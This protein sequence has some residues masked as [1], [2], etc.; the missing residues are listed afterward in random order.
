MRSYSKIML[1]PALQILY[2][3]EEIGGIIS[4]P[5]TIT[6]KGYIRVVHQGFD[7]TLTAWR[8]QRLSEHPET[9]RTLCDLFNQLIFMGNFRAS[10]WF[11]KERAKLL[12]KNIAWTWLEHKTKRPATIEDQSYIL[13]KYIIPQSGSKSVQELT[14]QDFYWIRENHGDTQ[15]ANDIRSVAGAILNWAWKEGMMDRQ[16]FLPV[17]SVPKKPTPYIEHNDRWRIYA[18]IEPGYQDPVLLSIE[19]GMRVGEICALRWDAI[20]LEHGIIKI[21]RSLSKYQVVDMRKGGDEIW[22]Q[23]TDKV[24]TMLE[25]RRKVSKSHWVFIGKKG[26]H[27][28]TNYVSNAF[29]RAA[30][31]CGL[32]HARLH[33]CRH[34]IAID[35]G[36]EGKSLEETQE[37][38]GHRERKTTEGYRGMMGFRRLRAAVE[39]ERR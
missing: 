1:T 10:D 6:Q 12:I 33:H 4:M 29:K 7:K 8:N 35:D 19:M 37:R 23:M 20:N 16:L 14:R 9:T 21:I 27:L 38:L 30:R 36:L 18:K 32:P 25:S 34:S 5:A 17:I 26:N 11:P 22:L 15:M 24:K 3:L 2:P 28:W 39:M 13:K 31:V